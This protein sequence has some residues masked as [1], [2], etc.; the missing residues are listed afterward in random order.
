MHWDNY[1]LRAM[2]SSLSKHVIK[3]V[4]LG[5]RQHEIVAM[6]MQRGLETLNSPAERTIHL[7]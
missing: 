4:I 7:I 2:L 3:L 6:S 5:L 1:L